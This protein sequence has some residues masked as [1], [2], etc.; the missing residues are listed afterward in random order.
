VSA[1]VDPRWLRDA[2]VDAYYDA[3]P[4][5]TTNLLWFA[6]TLPLITAPPAAAGLYYVTN[7]LAHRRSAGWRT[8]FEGFRSAF[9]LA[10]RWALTNLLALAML[11]G[12]T[13][14]YGKMGAAWSSWAQG[15]LLGLAVLWG[16]LQT[17]T[18]P[19]LLE[20]EDRRMVT[21][22]RNS[23]VLFIRYPVTS[24]GLAFLI[25]LL[26]VVSTL[27][28]PPSWLLVTASL[29]TYLA[30]R[31]TIVMMTAETPGG[32]HEGADTRPGQG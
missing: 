12:S 9:W 18:F 17:Y 19:L 15:L 13:W 22:V 21:A 10:W 1:R 8:F 2:L 6:L 29:G 28:L 30:N 16:L 26:M 11:G 7:R 14:L 20:Q 25:V 27:L 32:P 23:I 4:L 24:L 31:C 3:I 5:I